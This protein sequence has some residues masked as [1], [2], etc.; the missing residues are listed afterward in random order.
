MQIDLETREDLIHLLRTTEY[1]F[2]IFKFTATWCKPCAKIK[3][4]V[5]DMVEEKINQLNAT[6]KQN[7]FLFVEVDIDECFDIY[8]FLK[9]K[10][11]INGVPSL[12]AYN[13]EIS[14]K[15]DES[16]MYLPHGNVS[17]TNE[18]DIRRLFDMIQ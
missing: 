14:R 3:S 12:F 9:K 4:F 11:V 17:G 10:K 2:V 6:Q 1:K 5:N 18:G 8:S 7:H 16:Y 15:T 13:T